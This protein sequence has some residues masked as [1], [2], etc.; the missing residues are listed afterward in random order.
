MDRIADVTGRNSD[1]IAYRNTWGDALFAVVHSAGEAAAIALEL[2]DHLATVDY[3]KLGIDRAA[4][5]RIGAH[6]GPVYSGPDKVTGDINFFGTEVNR[7]ARMEPVTPPGA[8]YVSEAF[9]ATL[10]LQEPD[11]FTCA[12]VGQVE[13][14]KGFGA[15]RMYRLSRKF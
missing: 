1:A 10:A 11:R 15:Q 9:A 6:L 8:V 4:G 12:Y 14:P 13:L 3:S 5:M 7:A 2:Q